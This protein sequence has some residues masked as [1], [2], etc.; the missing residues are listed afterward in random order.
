MMASALETN[1]LNKFVGGISSL[2][3]KETETETKVKKENPWIQ[4]QKRVRD[5]TGFAPTFNMKYCSFLKQFAEDSGRYKSYVDLSDEDIKDGGPQWREAED[6]TEAAVVE[7]WKAAATLEDATIVEAAAYAEGR[8]I[9]AAVAAAKAAAMVAGAGTGTVAM[10]ARDAAKAAAA[11]ERDVP[12]K[13]AVAAKKSPKDVAEDPSPPLAEKASVRDVPEKKPAAGKKKAN[14]QAP[15]AESL[16]CEI[17]ALEKAASDAAAASEKDDKDAKIATDRAAAARKEADEFQK[18]ADAAVSAAS[19]KKAVLKGAQEQVQKKRAELGKFL[20]DAAAASEKK[21][22]LKEAQE[23]VQK[24]KADLDKFLADTSSE[25]VAV[26][27][28]AA[29][30]VAAASEP[31]CVRRKNIPKHIKTLVWNKYIGVDIAQADCVCCR[32]QKI[33]VRSFHC[34][35]VIAESRGGDLNINNLRPIC[36]ECNGAMTTN[37]M[38]EF[39][40]EFFGWSI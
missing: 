2:D 28:A 1:R 32:S 26:V 40:K 25:P 15:T 12:K 18:K 36:A 19:E 13:K 27:A 21:A 4:F 17:T 20:A 38:N 7:A 8:R 10:A 30:S 6:A 34:G 16:E 29:E 35:H 3:I 39:T 9:F 11:L 22:A 23:Q 33:N 31:I 5:L 14:A 24:K 37:S